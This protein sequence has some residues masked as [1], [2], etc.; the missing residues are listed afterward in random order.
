MC[1]G[2]LPIAT[3]ALPALAGVLLISAV[4]ELGKQWAFSV[5]GAV[6]LLSLILAADKEAVLLFILFFGYYPVVKAVLEKGS[7]KW[8][9]YIWKFLIFNAAMIGTFFASVYIL[10]NPMEEFTLGGVFLPW[11]LLLLGNGVFL[12]YDYAISGV[13]FFYIQR[14]HGLFSKWLRKK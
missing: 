9:A 2:L 3:Y 1:T 6:S 10:G 7:R 8:M 5:Y 12:L 4:I 14:F 11:I 13:V